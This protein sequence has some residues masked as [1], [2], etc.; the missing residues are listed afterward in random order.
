MLACGISPGFRDLE[1]LEVRNTNVS[2]VG[3]GEPVGASATA[4]VAYGDTLMTDALIE[5][6]RLLPMTQIILDRAAVSPGIRY[7]PCLL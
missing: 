2:L 5:L 3:V 6:Q 1:T 7:S 4:A